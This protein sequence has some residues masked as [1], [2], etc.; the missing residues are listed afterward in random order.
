MSHEVSIY[1][2]KNQLSK[3]I[4][5]AGQGETVI[6]TKNNTPIVKLLYIGPKKR[7]IYGLNAGNLPSVGREAFSPLSDE[8]TKEFYAE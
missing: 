5:L 8:E 2:A 3:L 4:A 6:I 1:D 7:P